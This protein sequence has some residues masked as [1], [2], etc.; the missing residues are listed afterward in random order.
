ML[1]L[2]PGFTILAFVTCKCSFWGV[3]W[4]KTGVILSDLLPSHQ[5]IYVRLACGRIFDSLVWYHRG[6]TGPHWEH[7][8]ASPVATYRS[9]LQRISRAA[10][11]TGSI[12]PGLG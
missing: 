12:P 10:Y 8:I 3:G 1:A 6:R 11:R 9:R 5:R 7:R 4:D 2:L